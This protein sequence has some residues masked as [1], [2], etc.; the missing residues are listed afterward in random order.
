[1]DRLQFVADRGHDLV[2]D[3]IGQGL[4]DLL[5]GTPHNKCT[6][7]ALDEDGG[8]EGPKMALRVPIRQ[9]GILVGRLGRNTER[10]YLFVSPPALSRM[11]NTAIRLPDTAL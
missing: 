9:S 6:P 5:G 3:G 10:Y 11:P 2:V 1:M 7:T 4:A 8:Q